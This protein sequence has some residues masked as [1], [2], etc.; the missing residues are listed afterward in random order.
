MGLF[1]TILET[2]IVYLGFKHKAD[3]VNFCRTEIQIFKFLN[4]PKSIDISTE[5]KTNNCD[6]AC[7]S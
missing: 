5:G 4:R 3:I 2:K 1:Q 7:Q 6:L